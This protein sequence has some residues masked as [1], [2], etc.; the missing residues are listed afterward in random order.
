MDAGINTGSKPAR[1]KSPET[2]TEDV[3]VEAQEVVITLGDAVGDVMPWWTADLPEPRRGNACRN[4]DIICDG[5]RVTR[6]YCSSCAQIFLKPGKPNAPLSIPAL[7]ASNARRSIQKINARSKN[8][9]TMRSVSARM[10]IAA[11]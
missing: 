8:I 3:K 2:Q 10:L 1:S 9:E 7:R 5:E 4:P 6:S 11:E